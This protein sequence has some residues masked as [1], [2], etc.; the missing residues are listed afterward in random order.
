MLT[1]EMLKV[2]ETLI[3]L[4]VR[5]DMEEFGEACQPVT[6]GEW[7]PAIAWAKDVL[8]QAERARMLEVRCTADEIAVLLAVIAELRRAQGLHEPM[9]G[10]LDGYATIQCEVAELAREVMRENPQPQALRTEA[11][12]VAAM[13]VRFLLDVCGGVK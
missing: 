5:S 7:F 11:V 2:L 10:P 6:N 3:D 4:M 13:G 1:D 8:E 9:A 12:Q